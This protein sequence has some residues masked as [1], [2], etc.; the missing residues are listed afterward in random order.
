M[1]EFLTVLY[2]L[3]THPCLSLHFEQ[4]LSYRDSSLKNQS[5]QRRLLSYRCLKALPNYPAAHH[6]HYHYHSVINFY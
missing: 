1:S 2:I 6:Y 3:L 5:S 4:D